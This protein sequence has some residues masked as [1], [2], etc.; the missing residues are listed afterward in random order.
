MAKNKNGGFEENEKESD[1][2]KAS[3]WRKFWTKEALKL[4]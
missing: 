2:R 1:K 3:L 4:Q